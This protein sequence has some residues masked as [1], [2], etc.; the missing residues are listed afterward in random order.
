[1]KKEDK[2]IVISDNQ[3]EVTSYGKH[4]GK[5]DRGAIRIEFHQSIG[6]STQKSEDILDK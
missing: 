1:M 5:D 6:G 3:E 4:E 2:E